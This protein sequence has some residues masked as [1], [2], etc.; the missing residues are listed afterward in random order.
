MGN[1]AKFY[2]KVTDEEIEQLHFA[3]K[4]YYYRMA[5]PHMQEFFV[6]STL[7]RQAEKLGHKL[8]WKEARP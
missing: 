4:Q 6:P 7:H 2:R 3:P 8:G 1:P 5:R